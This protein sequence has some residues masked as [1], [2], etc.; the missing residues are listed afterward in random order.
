MVAPS[1]AERCNRIVFDL[2]FLAIEFLQ[3]G[4]R[5]AALRVME[6]CSSMLGESLFG[7]DDCS[8]MQLA[9]ELTAAEGSGR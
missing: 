1:L 3:S 8:P 6:M 7:G 2:D 4:R 9:Q 5:D